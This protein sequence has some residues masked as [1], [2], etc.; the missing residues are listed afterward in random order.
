M[1]ERTGLSGAQGLMLAGVAALAVAAGVAW[2]SGAFAPGEEASSDGTPVAVAVPKKSPAPEDDSVIAPP[3]EADT[4]GQAED[5]AP[6]A[7]KVI[8]EALAT[9]LERAGEGS[10]ATEDT[11]LAPRSPRFDLVRVEPD[12][13]TTVAGRAEPG[14]EVTIELDGLAAARVAAAGDGSFV[15]FLQLEPSNNPRR[16]RLRM[17]LADGTVLF[18]DGSALIAPMPAVVPVEPASPQAAPDQQQ[19]TD[20]AEA[21]T[22]SPAEAA[23]PAPGA[24]SEEP[25]PAARAESEVA[26]A[27]GPRPDPQPAPASEAPSG[28]ALASAEN[29]A[30]APRAPAVIITRSD[31]ATLVQPPAPVGD[32]MP[33]EVMSA[34]A[35]DTITYSEEGEVELSGRGQGS[36]FVRVYVDNRPVTTSRI[37][38]DGNWR[39]G[40]PDVD[41]GVYTLRVDELDEEGEVVS[42]VETP[43]K[44][45]A[46]EVLAEVGTVTAITVQPGNTLWAIARDAY[47]EGL[48][49]VRLF[50]ANKDRIRDP[51]LIYPGQ[52]FDIPRD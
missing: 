30:P 7:E 44:R 29:P 50:E 37:S 42:R 48:L 22:P 39:T 13:S 25:A 15:Q 12:G 40:L 17:A 47:G 23:D 5:P 38:P 28:D 52:V 2:Y 41:T 6:S 33:P 19:P 16:I 8:S 9:A 34:V 21:E 24:M 10:A 18:S 32:T 4:A 36:G 27:P 35:L 49:Y 46:Q 3:S 51:D 31:G 14:S 20:I 45:E 1:S 43:F 26:A 11:V